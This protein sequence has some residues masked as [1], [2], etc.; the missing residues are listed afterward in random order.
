MTIRPK[1]IIT[2]KIAYQPASSSVRPPMVGE[3]AGPSAR[4]MPM[5]FMMREEVSPSNWS[6]TMARAVA[7]PTDAPTPCR[8]RAAISI[9]T[10]AAAMARIAPARYSTMKPSVVTRRPKAS[11]IGPQTSWVS[12]KPAK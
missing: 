5:V 6:R 12:A 8:M 3:T 2:T 9:S 10:F 1:N 11:D 4:M 7:T